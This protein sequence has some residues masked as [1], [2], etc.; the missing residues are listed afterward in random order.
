MRVLI[1]GAD[2]FLGRHLVADLPGHTVICASRR[3]MP[4]LDWRPLP[5]LGG[6]VDWAPLLQGVDAVVHLA[7]IAH[8]QASEDDFARVNQ[9]ATASLCAAAKAADIRQLVYVSSIYA[10]VGHL[11]A[12]VI[13]ETDAPTP[14]NAYGRSKLAT[15]RAVA[16]SGVPYTVLRPAL[17][18][19]AGAKGNAG[20]LEKLA[21]L[22]LPLP[23]GSI[24]AKRS[25]LSVENF[26]GAVATVLGDPRALGETYIVADPEPRT[27][28]EV[29]ADMRTRLG[30]SP[31]LFPVPRGSVELGL[32]AIGGRGI[33]EKIGTPFIASADKLRALGW[34]PKR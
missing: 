29:V 6:D 25:F 7:N 32:K 9:R 21:R 5:D 1:T 17:V 8:Q 16:E 15:E 19:G 34:K 26:P 24:D 30:R 18:L 11:S 33:W 22:P 10:Q 31:N 27:V 12:R 3:P 13:R 23:I 2:G 14:I 20:T 4:G 28:G